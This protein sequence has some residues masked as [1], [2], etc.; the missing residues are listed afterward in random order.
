[1]VDVA[2]FTKDTWSNNYELVVLVENPGVL[3][4]DRGSAVQHSLAYL[5]RTRY[6]RPRIAQTMSPSPMHVI[7]WEGQWHHART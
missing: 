5:L 2:N 6:C 3:I 1:M 4:T 7:W